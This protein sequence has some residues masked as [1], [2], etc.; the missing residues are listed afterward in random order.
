MIV[1]VGD[2]YWMSVLKMWEELVKMVNSAGP[3]VRSISLEVHE[4]FRQEEEITD[5]E[6]LDR[7]SKQLRALNDALKRFPLLD[8]V[9]L[10]VS[11][12]HGWGP[13]V[14]EGLQTHLEQEGL[15]FTHETIVHPLSEE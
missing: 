2:Y 3:T 10:R 13:D 11:D 8:K 14:E 4:S 9:H 1:A 12:I 5:E 7:I 6:Y 15:R